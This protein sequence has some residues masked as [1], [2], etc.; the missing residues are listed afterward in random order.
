MFSVVL[1]L[2]VAASLA[3]HFTSWISRI[4]AGEAMIPQVQKQHRF[5]IDLRTRLLHCNKRKL[6]ISIE[7]IYFEC[8]RVKS[9]YSQLPLLSITSLLYLD[10]L[11]FYGGF[12]T[13]I[14]LVSSHTNICWSI[15]C[16]LDTCTQ[17]NDLQFATAT[18]VPHCSYDSASLKQVT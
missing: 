5:L 18:Q 3:F 14:D 6:Q 2:N 9:M 16:Y 15:L 8:D 7:R 17:I 13:S 1:Q 12:A 10:V 4:K 11:Q